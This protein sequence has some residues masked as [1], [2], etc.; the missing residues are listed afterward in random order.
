MKEQHLKE[1]WVFCFSVLLV[2]ESLEFENAY[3][4]YDH[5]SLLFVSFV[6]P[7]RVSELGF[8]CAPTFSIL[9]CERPRRPSGYRKWHSRTKSFRRELH[10]T[11]AKSESD[12]LV[13]SA[14]C[15]VGR[16]YWELCL[17]DLFP[18]NAFMLGLL[19]F[20]GYDADCPFQLEKHGK[21][22]SFKSAYKALYCATV[23]PL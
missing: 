10:L 17:I 19:K 8:C 15:R 5:L 6:R 14:G 2:F 13:R 1:L 11:M 22:L 4:Y 7:I 16:N 9:A 12:V 18:L 21:H 23:P 3:K 20:A